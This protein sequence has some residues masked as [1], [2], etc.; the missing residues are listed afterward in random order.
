[1][2]IIVEISIIYGMLGM[3]SLSFYLIYAI[4]KDKEKEK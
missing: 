4:N 3:G 2:Q 1:M